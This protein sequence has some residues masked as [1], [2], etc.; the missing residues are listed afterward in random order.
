M[1]PC[2]LAWSSGPQ[3]TL[4]LPGVFTMIMSAI[5]M[6]RKMSSARMRWGA[7]AGGAAAVRQR[8][9]TA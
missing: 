1:K 8:P 6:P 3:A 2:Q 4:P 7:V 9:V 5:V